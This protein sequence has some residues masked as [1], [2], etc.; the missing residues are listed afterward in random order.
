MQPIRTT[1]GTL[2]S[3]LLALVI[4]TLL[5]IQLFQ[6]D[7]DKLVKD[8][9]SYV[10]VASRSIL[11]KDFW[12]GERPFTIPLVYK[13]LGLTEGMSSNQQSIAVVTRFQLVFHILS[14]STLAV[15]FFFT[16]NHS[17]IAAFFGLFA[18]LLISLSKHISQWNRIVSSESLSTSLFILALALGLYG[19]HYLQRKKRP[20]VLGL[21]TYLVC[22]I[23]IH[24]LYSFT[25]D[26]NAYFLLCEAII[27]VG[28]SLL[29]RK[30]AMWAR[31]SVL[32]I[33]LVL[34][35]IYL[36]QN[37][38]VNRGQRWFYPFLNVF[39][40]R[41]LNNRDAYGYFLNAGMPEDKLPIE[42]I[43]EMKR[44]V[45]IVHMYNDSRAKDQRLWLLQHGKGV[46]LSYMISNPA[47]L[48]AGPVEDARHIISPNST[49]Y[50]LQVIPTPLWQEVI[51]S[52]IYPQSTPFVI[53]SLFLLVAV[54]ILS[55]SRV[56]WRFEF[57]VPWLLILTA[58]PMFLVVWHGDAIELE[59]HAF[60]ISLQLRLA[61]WSLVVFLLGSI[62]VKKQH[63]S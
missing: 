17:R 33:A 22:L 56:G 18:I 52:W 47:S 43:R 31:Y 41:F 37:A 16:M 54:S 25:R 34:G 8:T 60:Q 28:L 9:S 11:D 49:E 7:A 20:R 57:I 51:T 44:D 1:M 14:W 27:L 50:R 24:F 38:I 23:G 42:T 29:A 6:L 4:F 48:L 55:V 10:T 19:L 5:S 45:F 40:S 63:P 62:R 53:I 15:I 26:T 58:F 59:R 30:L 61:F 46:Y 2:A 35:S 13:L 36:L 12:A 39:H 3:I 32:I 21:T